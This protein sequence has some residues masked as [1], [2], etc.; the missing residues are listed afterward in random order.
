M[1][2]L[3]KC[4]KCLELKRTELFYKDRHCPDGLQKICNNCSNKRCRKY[5]EDNKEKFKSF[6]KYYYQKNKQR[7][8]PIARERVIKWAKDNPNKVK[9]NDRR[10]QLRKRYPE[11]LIG[12]KILQLQIRSELCKI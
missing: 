1:D 10:R 3:K 8:L 11:E 7:L 9:G 5:Y 4:T 12:V 6:N 2:E